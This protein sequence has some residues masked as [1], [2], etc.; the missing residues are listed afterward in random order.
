MKF[1]YLSVFIFLVFLAPF[2]SASEEA[3]NFL[4][5]NWVAE[6]PSGAGVNPDGWGL[7]SRIDISEHWF[8]RGEYEDLAGGGMDVEAAELVL[9]YVLNPHQQYVFH[10]GASYG[11]ERESGN[12][13]S[14]KSIGRGIELGFHSD[15][16]YGFVLHGEA[17]W[18][19]GNGQEVVGGELGLFYQIT[20]LVGVN[21]EYSLDENSNSAIETGIRFTF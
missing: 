7:L 5:V 9:T 3:H 10:V 15:I 1:F 2:S 6:N 11:F 16:G 20:E 8:V 17:A 4:Q 18:E 19:T 12:G 14:N 21:L 13:P